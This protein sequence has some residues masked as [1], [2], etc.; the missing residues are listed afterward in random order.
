MYGALLSCRK[1]WFQP[2]VIHTAASGYTHAHA[3]T[4][5]QKWGQRWGKDI[6][7]KSKLSVSLFGAKEANKLLFSG[8]FL[9]KEG[10][11]HSIKPRLFGLLQ[12][13]VF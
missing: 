2:P 1:P 3:H 5:E 10:S 11:L 12:A 9:S 4:P 8:L 6:K 7:I 13:N